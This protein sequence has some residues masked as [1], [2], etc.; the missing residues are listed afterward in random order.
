MEEVSSSLSSEIDS[1]TKELNDVSIKLA[2]ITDKWK[3]AIDQYKKIQR[4]ADEI[5]YYKLQVPEA[6]LNEIL[7]LREVVPYLRNSEPLN[8]V[9]WKTY[10]ERPFTDLVGRV[11]G[12]TQVTGIYKI[13]NLKNQMSYIGQAVNVKERF[14]QHIKRGLGAEP[15]TRNK[16]Y[17]AMKKDGVENFMFEII[18][19]CPRE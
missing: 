10:Y 8:K 13:T 2:E 1:K 4:E 7:R 17:T 9:I 18:E 19:K 15:Q 6:D 5:E 16:I 3:T 11:V 12:S 14:R